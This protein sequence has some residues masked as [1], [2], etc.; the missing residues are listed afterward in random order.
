MDGRG[1]G[2][3][4]PL[5]T[6]TGALDG[7]SDRTGSM[8]AAAAPP[9]EDLGPCCS[10]PAR[11]CSPLAVP[12]WCSNKC[13]GGLRGAGRGADPTSECTSVQCCLPNYG[14][15]V[16]RR[17]EKSQ[18]TSDAGR[19]TERRLHAERK[20]QKTAALEAPGRSEVALVESRWLPIAGVRCEPTSEQQPSLWIQAQ[21]RNLSWANGAAIPCE[22]LTIAKLP[23]FRYGSHGYKL[24]PATTARS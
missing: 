11:L 16:N 18:G 6:S 2:M 24:K 9:S 22:Q 3:G 5:S 13:L 7:Q 10:W 23:H 14:T 17:P 15:A 12:V 4:T 8:H 19:S 20:R 21:S 1:E